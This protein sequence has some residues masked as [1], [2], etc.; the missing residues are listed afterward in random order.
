MKQKIMT[1]KAKDF[2]WDFVRGSG[3]GG[4]KK[5]KT[6]S[7]VRCTHRPSGAAAWCENGRSQI[8]NRREAFKKCANSKQFRNWL[9]IEVS[10][11]TRD[12]RD[13]LEKQVDALMAD[14]FLKIEIIP[15]V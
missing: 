1:I 6:C 9:R 4:Q 2:D 10:R 15:K 12:T 8:H 7:A 3:K 13:D 5:N 14:K 11:Q